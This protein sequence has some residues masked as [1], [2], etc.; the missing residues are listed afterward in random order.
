LRAKCGVGRFTREKK[1][2]DTSTVRGAWNQKPDCRGNAPNHHQGRAEWKPAGIETPKARLFERDGEK[3]TAGRGRE[4][5][6]PSAF[7]G[8]M[9]PSV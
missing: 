9:G 1:H 6:R 3:A 7:E 8:E 4:R 5:V 2:R